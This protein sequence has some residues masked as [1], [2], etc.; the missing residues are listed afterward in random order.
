M[1]TEFFSLNNRRIPLSAVERGAMSMRRYDYYGASGVI[2]K[3][4]NYLFDERTIADC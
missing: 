4:E 2:D 1:K 3:V